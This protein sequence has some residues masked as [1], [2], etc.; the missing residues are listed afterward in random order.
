VK[1]YIAPYEI[2]NGHLMQGHYFK[3]I[4]NPGNRFDPK[5]KWDLFPYRPPPGAPNALP[6]KW[7]RFYDFPDAFLKH[8]NAT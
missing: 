1:Y 2:R 5:R 7:R 6:L 4:A 3:E 8:E